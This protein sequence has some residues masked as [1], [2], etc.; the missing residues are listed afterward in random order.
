MFDDVNR[1]TVLRAGLGGLSV[2]A[3][4]PLAGSMQG[5]FAQTGRVLKINTLASAAAVNVPMQAALRSGVG[6][7]AGFAAPEVRPTK[8]IPQIAQEVI[9]G[10]ADLG[11][12]D[13]AST[14]AAAEAGADL[15][16]IGLSY[17]NTSQVIVANTDKVKSL[18][19]IAAKGG[20]I[21]VNSIG[22]FMYV[23]LAGALLKRNI[24]PKKVNFIEMGSSGDRARALVA[25]RVDA[26][27]MHI[28]Q[29]LEL[30]QMGS[31]EMLVRPWEEYDNWFSAI[32]MT[33][34]AWLKAD[35]NKRAA[36]AVLK[37]VLTSFRNTNK[38]YGW[39]KTQ[40]GQYAS[41]KE[42]KAADDSMLK[43]VWETLTT[44][45][46][47]FPNNMETLT[48]DEF[49]KVI[50]AYKAVGALKGTVDL[51]KVIDRTYL[52]QAVKELA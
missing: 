45:I 5:A 32:V 42:L 1:R 27:P 30:A 8:K 33:T 44:R 47:A 21:A 37:S 26:V 10:A 51:T 20:T 9:A 17:S 35:E 28:E 11:D 19:E 52:E 16:I 38:D 39:F 12:A 6:M 41:S 34:G 18:E 49:A 25:G 36:V 40:V 29:A 43:P 3:L 23:M 31:Y 2:L 14:L 15:R 48:P 7:M 46:K 13:V 22:D 24:D 50:P 4:G